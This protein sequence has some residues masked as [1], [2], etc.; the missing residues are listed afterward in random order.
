MQSNIMAE[1]GL[2]TTDDSI[3]LLNAADYSIEFLPLL[4]DSLIEVS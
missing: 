3:K 4:L 2:P 1:L